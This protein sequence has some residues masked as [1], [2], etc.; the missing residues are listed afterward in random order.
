MS[1]KDATL[2]EYKRTDHAS[3]SSA[4]GAVVA[5]ELANEAQRA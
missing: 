1:L 5:W 3:A 2:A 4:S